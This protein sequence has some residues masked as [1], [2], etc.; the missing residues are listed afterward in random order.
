[1]TRPVYAG[2][3]N[4]GT[5]NG[6]LIF[7][8][9]TAGIYDTTRNAILNSLAGKLYGGGGAH[10]L[11][12]KTW[13][14]GLAYSNGFGYGDQSGR[15]SYYAERCPDVAQTM[16][17]VVNVLKNAEDDPYL[18][19]YAIAQAFGSTRAG[20]R[21]ERRG[22]AMAAD[23][24]DGFTPD[25]VRNYRQS[26]LKV[27]NMPNLYEELKS[28]M[29]NVYGQVLIGYGPPL[30]KSKNGCFFVIGPDAQ[31][32]SLSRYIQNTEGIQ[33]ICHLYPRDFWLTM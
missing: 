32:K 17:F 13:G 19:E 33:N 3:V 10:G 14:A 11:F 28:R 25:V 7:T 27:R 1:M 30:E 9:T 18:S 24:A 8:A 26:I 16:Q 15:V 2:L 29:A 23:L 20:A 5:R 6:V 12:M 21:Y 4:E 31:F 22:E